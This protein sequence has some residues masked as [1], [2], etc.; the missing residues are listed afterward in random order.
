[1]SEDLPQG[2]PATGP[3]A[4][5]PA[6]NKRSLVLI[7]FVILMD[8]IGITLLSPVAPKIVL[9]YNSSAVMVTM[10]T[11]IYAAG[12]F[13]SSPL[14]GR[15]GDK[16]GRRPVLLVSLVGQS[17]GYFIFGVAGSLW[18]LFLGRLIGGIT[19]GNISTSSA[20]IA[21]I[22][23]PEERSKN[24]AM[25][26]TA[27]S[28]GLILGPAMGGILGTIN[29][30]APA[31]AA[32]VI[33]LIN[34]ILAY[35]LLP[36]TLPK[37]KRDTTPLRP[38][39]YNPIASI[40]DMARK[41]GLGLLLLVNALF[42]F[43]F[44]GINST[45]ALYM[46]QK[47]SAETWQISVM[48]M[49]SG[50]S[51]AMANSFL[52]PRWVPRFGERKSGTSGLLGLAFFSVS[53]FLAPFLWLA[54]FLN[55]LGSAMSAFIFPSITTLSVGLVSPREVGQLLGVTSAVGSLMNIFGPLCA[56]FIYDHL[57]MG[58]PYWMGAIILV[59][60]ALI[61]F[62]TAPHSQPINLA[63]ETIEE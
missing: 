17:L 33:T 40:G 51:I 47:F 18:M 3:L 53:V 49:M 44:N 30:R 11:V 1:L 29:L 10:V 14:L 23:K 38:R 34:V 63:I 57:M 55:M 12:Q 28:L 31:I 2:E 41:P 43:A 46:I 7:F 6:S 48:M 35:F 45:S 50:L 15:I 52:V 16:V 27:W 26:S 59:M 24:F 37:E 36:E 58:S 61:L 5:T 9:E 4:I 54:F 8:I 19:S 56:G 20:Y 21:D 22:S 39:D 42:S 13:F 60:A 25:I 32:G 62:R